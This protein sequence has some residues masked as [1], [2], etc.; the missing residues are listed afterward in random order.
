M[1]IYKH[2]RTSYRLI[3]VKIRWFLVLTTVLLS[4][5]ALLDLF[6]LGLIFPIAKLLSG[7]TT[8]LSHDIFTP[9]RGHIE[10]IAP[11]D[12][13]GIIAICF[14]V[15]LIFKGIV[16]T[17]IT[18]WTSKVLMLA[19]ARFNA[20][21]FKAYVNAPLSYHLMHHSSEFIRNLN[22]NI[23][24]LYRNTAMPV[25]QT[26]S[27]LM[28]SLGVFTVLIYAD[29]W[30]AM[31]SVIILGFG[32]GIY[33]FAIS[34]PISRMAYEAHD[35]SL[36]NL[37]V[38]HEAMDSIPEIR[39][40]DKANF[41]LDHFA[42]IRGKIATISYKEQ[43]I[44]NAP[45]FVLEALIG[46][47][48]T[49]IILILI[50]S[51][52]DGEEV[53]T[54]LV[55]YAVASIRLMPVV[56]RIVATI[57]AAR[58]A[59]PSVQ[60]L[61]Q[62]VEE[63]GGDI[64]LDGPWILPNQKKLV[65]GEIQGF[66]IKLE[67][68]EISHFYSSDIVALNNVSL[69]IDR[70]QSIG[71]VGHSGAGKTTLA[72]VILGLIHPSK[73]EVLIDGLPM[74]LDEPA[75][76]RSIGYVPQN[77]VMLDDTIRA[78]IAFGVEPDDIDDAWVLRAIERADLSDF[79]ASHPDGLDARVGEKGLRISG[80]QRQR[81]GIA[82]AL[83]YD[84]AILVLDEATSALDV[85]TEARISHV[86]QKLHGEKT[87]IIIAHR[88]STIQNCDKVVFMKDGCISDTGTFNDLI[89]KNDD[90]RRLVDHARLN[91]HEVSKSDNVEAVL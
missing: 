85:E 61:S 55:L 27:E 87:L 43:T 31:I 52:K 90:F 51:G 89:G 36:R 15:L 37:R 7:D 67:I 4:F 5:V 11:K 66:K 28:L 57:S 50:S 47:M 2:Y 75:I 14:V 60:Q 84:P 41:F 81:V 24:K 9:I 49:A 16:A 79:I 76:L 53:M 78:N 83:Y 32:G 30:A 62:D 25:A 34:K 58:T 77:I 3:D 39:A 73:G 68:R 45:R 18:Y 44:M 1:S 33:A 6:G 82:R 63:F 69:T 19:E 86:I 72:G 42:K 48:V 70:G 88:L 46:I 91:V 8:F 38:M 20:R 71:L 13:A 35:L 29:P 59:I 40:F 26:V 74:D 80:G 21:L 23:V 65:P 12:L 64:V 54:I 56:T 22:D 10:G 17:V